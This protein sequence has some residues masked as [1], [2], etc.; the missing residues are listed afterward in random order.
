MEYLTGEYLCKCKTLTLSCK[1]AKQKHCYCN[2]N[3]LAN[4]SQYAK[5]AQNV[6]QTLKH[7]Y[8]LVM[9]SHCS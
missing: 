8:I 7:S 4:I 5:F 6:R 9:R 3:S 1:M 2:N